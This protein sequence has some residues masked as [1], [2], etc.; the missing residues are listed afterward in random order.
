MK[1]HRNVKV[2]N[3]GEKR[4]ASYKTSNTEQGWNNCIMKLSDKKSDKKSKGNE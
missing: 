3:S 2:I 1:E 4:Q